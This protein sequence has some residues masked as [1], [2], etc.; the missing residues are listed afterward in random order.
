MVCTGCLSQEAELI[1]QSALER[2][3]LI[4]ER[5]DSAAYSL[6]RDLWGQTDVVLKNQY[7]LD[8]VKLAFNEPQTSFQVTNCRKKKGGNVW[9]S[10]VWELI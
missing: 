9:S 6:H 8:Y 1:V 5:Q 2:A 10:W 3:G 7:L 4:S